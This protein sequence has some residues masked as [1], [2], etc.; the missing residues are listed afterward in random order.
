MCS[1]MHIVRS[2]IEHIPRGEI[3]AIL[4][5]LFEISHTMKNMKISR[6][7]TFFVLLCLAT[8][9][10]SGFWHSLMIISK[11][12]VSAHSHNIP[13]HE[14]H[15]SEDMAYRW[16]LISHHEI[17][18]SF[19]AT[20]PTYLAYTHQDTSDKRYFLHRTK[21]FDKQSFFF[22]DTIRLLL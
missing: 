9:Y 14:I 19:D 22:S 13:D 2:S 1:S 20:Y 11:G 6:I 4:F 21:I 7:L 10:V 5:D 12:D 3:W 15:H 8:F 18:Y 16:S 17:E